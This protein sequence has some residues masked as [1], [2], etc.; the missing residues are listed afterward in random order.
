[1]SKRHVNQY[2]QDQMSDAWEKSTEGKCY[3]LGY[4][5]GYFDMLECVRVVLD[6]DVYANLKS[7]L[8]S[9]TDNIGS[10]IR[11]MFEKYNQT[12]SKVDDLAEKIE[13]I[14]QNTAEGK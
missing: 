3:A 10:H 9:R 11:I 4:A 1:M 13:V 14:K 12:N 6:E 5:G 7:T 8:V 2:M